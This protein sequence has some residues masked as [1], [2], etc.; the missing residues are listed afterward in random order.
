VS[1]T[2]FTDRRL[3]TR[4]HVRRSA[5]CAELF[6]TFTN[7]CSRVSAT[8]VPVPGVRCCMLISP[9]KSPRR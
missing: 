5:E 1:A 3:Q 4:Y 2:A 7:T 8:I 6:V 9:K